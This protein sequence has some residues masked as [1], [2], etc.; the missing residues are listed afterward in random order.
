[1]SHI[2]VYLPEGKVPKLKIYPSLPIWHEKVRDEKCLAWC[3]NDSV[4]VIKNPLFV[5]HVKSRVKNDFEN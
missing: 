1:M 3:F 5:L 4:P 2:H